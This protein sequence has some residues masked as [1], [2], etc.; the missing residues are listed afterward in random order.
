MKPKTQIP[1]KKNANA[2]IT[3]H[4]L[5]LGDAMTAKNGFAKNVIMEKITIMESIFSAIPALTA[6]TAQTIKSCKK[7]WPGEISRPFFI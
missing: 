5:R 2:E 7:D 4:T 6:A 1:K 3:V